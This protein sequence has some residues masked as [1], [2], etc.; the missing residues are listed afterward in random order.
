MCTKCGW[1]DL[2]EAVN[3]THPEA[4]DDGDGWFLRSVQAYMRQRHHI[5]DGQMKILRRLLKLSGPEP[6]HQTVYYTKSSQLIPV[7]PNSPFA[8]FLADKQQRRQT[9]NP[10]PKRKL[11]SR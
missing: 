11:N 1:D 7:R 6:E 4:L 9:R 3:E 2:L 5:T 10:K 8:Q